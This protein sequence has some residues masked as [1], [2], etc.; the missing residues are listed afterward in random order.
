MRLLLTLAVLALCLLCPA[1]AAAHAGLVQAEPA[2]GAVLPSAPPLVAL[3]F[4]ERLDP[5]FSRLRLIDERGQV[6]AETTTVDPADPYRLELAID[7][8]AVG[9]YTAVWRVRSAE[10]G[11]VTEGSVPFGVGVAADLGAVLPA[12]G[13]PMPAL[14][15]P[16]PLD[17]L[18]RWLA[19]AGAAL[20]VGPLLFGLLIWRPVWRREG[21]DR[22]SDESVGA[23]LRRL[24]LAGVALV[25]V[26][27]P[28][29]LFA[30]AVRAGG[31]GPGSLAALG[32]LLAGQA[33]V[34]LVLRLVGAG[35]VGVAAIWL[36]P[37][38]TGRAAAWWWGVAS[39]A[40]LLLSFP[41]SGHGAAAG[42]LAPLLIATGAIHTVAMAAW[43]G[44][45]AALLVAVRHAPRGPG[46]GPS[47]GALVRRFS[48]MA[49]AAV[50]AVSLSGAVAALAQIGAP[51]L[52]AATSY[53]RAL[54]VKSLAFCAMLG[55]GAFH[56][57][58]VGR[59]LQPGGAWAGRFRLT[60]GFE[61]G[62]A[63]VVLGGAAAQLSVAPSRAAWAA[64]EQL[65]QRFE[66]RADD[67]E[68]VLWV[69]PGSVG[70]N[71][72]ALD[73]EAAAAGPAPEVLFRFS[74]VGHP[75]A[76]LEAR[77]AE[78]EGGRYEARGSFLSMIGRWEVE[79]IVRRAGA[80]DVRQTFS[81]DVRGR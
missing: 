17:A 29:T 39:G 32:P 46:A 60:L 51:E 53:G 35:L 64:Q 56:M 78:T 43:F 70:D 57:L 71:L 69:T 26:A 42:E 19:L 79:T 81:V 45:L 47:H 27:T 25:F 24:I 40:L 12:P 68:L 72:V 74:M 77:A 50:V 36:L 34:M 23:A 49:V 80:R 37:P 48:A 55:L 15:P 14:A 28:L 18:G 30:Q 16:P 10:D 31:D 2:A 22:A 13:A 41:L 3:V 33:G 65:G 63:L 61:L 8:L 67:L 9:S 66:A 58:V 44:G 1:P 62:L 38:A 6:L 59:R 76:P 4:S 73:L 11:H 52:L 75:M 54:M 5:A 20:A 21:G 7:E